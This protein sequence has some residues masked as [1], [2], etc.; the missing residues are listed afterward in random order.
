MKK[1]GYMRKKIILMSFLLGVGT[2]SMLWLYSVSFM[3][4]GTVDGE[5]IYNYQLREYQKKEKHNQICEA[6]YAQI[7]Q[8]AIQTYETE[9]KEGESFEKYLERYKN[10]CVRVIY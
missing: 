3:P 2:V 7:W 6:V 1:Y 9:K 10:S 8:K 5:I 4:A